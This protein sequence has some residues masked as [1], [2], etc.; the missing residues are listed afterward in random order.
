[1][2]IY[3][4]ALL[5]EGFV[6][7]CFVKK[8]NSRFPSLKKCAHQKLGFGEKLKGF[9]SLNAYSGDP[10]IAGICFP[11]FFFTLILFCLKENEKDFL[12]PKQWAAKVY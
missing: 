6:L 1:M 7:C 10:I 2:S 5:G 9:G 3:G 8:S 12:H 11:C 4:E